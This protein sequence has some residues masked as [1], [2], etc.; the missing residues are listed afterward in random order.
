MGDGNLSMI[1]PSPIR[2]ALG[3][4]VSSET[5]PGE[6]PRA[7][8]DA[9]RLP[10]DGRR[11][12]WRDVSIIDA[13]SI[14]EPTNATIEPDVQPRLRSRSRLETAMATQRQARGGRE[15]EGGGKPRGEAGDR[16]ADRCISATS[17]SDDDG[18]SVEGGEAAFVDVPELPWPPDAGRTP[19]TFQNV[20]LSGSTFEPRR[21]E[22]MAPEAS[23]RRSPRGSVA[24]ARSETTRLPWKRVYFVWKYPPSLLLIDTGIL[25]RV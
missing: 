5:A 1:P 7:G 6:R 16:P 8:G 22:E 9:R 19:S 3:P 13:Q 20:I 21:D 18:G 24:E 11:G 14:G 10:E 2:R 12:R 17:E 4:R 23:G 15:V 25:S